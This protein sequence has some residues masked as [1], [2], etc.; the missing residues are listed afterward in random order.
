MILV[1]KGVLYYLRVQLNM[2]HYL[3]FLSNNNVPL[4][5]HYLANEASNICKKNPLDKVLATPF[6]HMGK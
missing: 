5:I 3:D 6:L 1:Y 2:A 4:G